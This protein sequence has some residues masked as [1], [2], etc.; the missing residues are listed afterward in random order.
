MSTMNDFIAGECRRAFVLGKPGTGKSYKLFNE[1]IPAFLKAQP[2]KEV[3]ILAFTNK[4]VDVVVDYAAQFGYHDHPLIHIT[5]IHK[6]AGLRPALNES[7]TRTKDLH[8]TQSSGECNEA[9]LV[10]ID[11]V[12][13][14]GADLGE[15]M[16]TAY[17][18][19]SRFEQMLFM[20]DY[21][22]LKPIEGDAYYQPEKGD[23]VV[24]LDEI[25]RTDCADVCAV[26]TELHDLIRDGSA[27]RYKLQPSENIIKGMPKGATRDALTVIA[28][29]N[30]AVQ[31]HNANLMGRK[32][33][34]AG[35]EL[36][37]D[38][39]KEVVHCSEVLDLMD[40]P[41]TDLQRITPVQADRYGNKLAKTDPARYK[42]NDE[43]DRF[44]TRQRFLNQ[45]K[46]RIDAEGTASGKIKLLELTTDSDEVFNCVAVF[47]IADHRETMAALLETA[48]CANRD[49]LAEYGLT[50]LKETTSR[51]RKVKPVIDRNGKQ[52]VN[53]KAFI[54]NETDCTPRD[55]WNA[56]I[57]EYKAAW[58]TYATAKEILFCADFN[59]ARTC[60][61]LQG[62]S[63]PVVYIDTA[64]FNGCR[65][66]DA[67]NRLLYVGVSRSRGKVY[68]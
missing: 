51:R 34:D 13:T 65:D 10:V 42:M 50:E 12:G 15:A 49:L 44:A 64:D 28:W 20:G 57:K 60:H 22:Q 4:A 39:L 6:F 5:T 41:Y 18:D 46:P 31:D 27:R 8:L 17:Y 59:R 7:A 26:I 35:D 45:I 62:S 29:R 9:H 58:G 52:L 19:E 61:S 54:D 63:V 23:P 67:V 11:E 68:F 3:A 43:T 66:Q 25:R 37:C 48:L 38:T 2:G 36:Y 30:R 55:H 24:Y 32:L 1:I 56:A 33:P 16:D 47:G 53:L 40:M 14:V 21:Q